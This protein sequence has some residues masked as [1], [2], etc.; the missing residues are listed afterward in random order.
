MI[1]PTLRI[2]AATLLF[3]MAALGD[4]CPATTPRFELQAATQNPTITFPPNTMPAS[5]T[6]GAAVKLV[7]GGASIDATVTDITPNAFIGGSIVTFQTAQPMSG[8]EGTDASGLTSAALSLVPPTGAAIDLC[9]LTPLN[10]SFHVGPT[11]SFGG[12]SSPTAD[13]AGAMRFQLSRG[14]LRM[15][16]VSSNKALIPAAR[17]LQEE[18]SVSIDTTDRVAKGAQ[19]VDDN[20]LTAAIRSPEKTFGM[21]LNRV[22]AGLQ[23]DFAKA[24][25]SEDRNTDLTITIDGWAPFFQALNLLSQTRTRTLPLSFRFSGGRRSQNVSG[26]RSTGN[27]ADGAITYHLYFLNNYAFDLSAETVFDGVKKPTPTT[28]RTQHSYKAAVSYKSDPLSKFSAVAT[29][30]N[31]HSGPV[32]T[33]LRQFFVGVGIQQLFAKAKTP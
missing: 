31:G 3:A 13:P 29:Y 7:M 18:L 22:R 2:L 5:I 6:K 25:H 26:V 17:N 16:P 10:Y 21:V 9:G 28:P 27:L 23:G 8:L 15:V 30:E 20:R 19:F 14:L 4:D 1:R 11:V 33:K 12:N 24:I 32:F